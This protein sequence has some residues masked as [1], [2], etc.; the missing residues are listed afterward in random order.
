MEEYLYIKEINIPIYRGC[1]VIIIT[2]SQTKLK[3]YLPDFPNEEIYAHSWC[4]K[5]KREQGF[6]MVL[7]FENDFRKIK[8][9]VITHEVIH[10]AHFIAEYR[11]IDPS[12]TNDE[13]IAYLAEWITDEVYKFIEKYNYKPL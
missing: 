9:G 10:I 6:I 3:K 7:N 13:S 11:A 12:F 1:F 5:Y 8:H 2:N 4:V